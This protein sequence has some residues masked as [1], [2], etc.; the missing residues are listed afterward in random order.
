M[1]RFL[2]SCFVQKVWGNH[3]SVWFC[4]IFQIYASVSLWEHLIIP[5]ILRLKGLWGFHMFVVKGLWRD[6]QPSEDSLFQAKAYTVWLLGLIARKWVCET[7]CERVCVPVCEPATVSQRWSMPAVPLMLNP[8]DTVPPS[9]VP[10]CA[11]RF[12]YTCMSVLILA[13]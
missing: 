12:V 5:A 10:Q 7:L 2:A 3:P 9:N 6:A 8:L 1:K 11:S 13:C 4:S